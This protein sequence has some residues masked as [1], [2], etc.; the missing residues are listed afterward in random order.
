[1]L[2]V[3]P[4]FWLKKG[5]TKKASNFLNKPK[6]ILILFFGCMIAQV[7]I[8]QQEEAPALYGDAKVQN[9]KYLRSLSSLEK[10]DEGERTQFVQKFAIDLNSVSDAKLLDD[11]WLKSE[12]STRAHN[13]NTL[14]PKGTRVKVYKNGDNEAYFAVKFKNKWGFIPMDSI[15]LME[16]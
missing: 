5:A 12:P 16:N 14:I 6:K 1:M 4:N 13:T 3:I 8:S 2:K 11:T 9:L 7:A 10:S 15:V